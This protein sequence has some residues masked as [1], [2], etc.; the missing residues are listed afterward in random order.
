MTNSFLQRLVHSVHNY[1]TLISQGGIWRC[2]SIRKGWCGCPQ[3]HGRYYRSAT[4]HLPT[5]L[6][7]SPLPL[8]P[9]TI[10][11][12]ISWN[13]HHSVP[14]PPK[15]HCR[16]TPSSPPAKDHQDTLESES[17]LLPAA[18]PESKATESLH[19]PGG[20]CW[21][22]LGVGSGLGNVGR[23]K[24]V[25]ACLDQMLS[26]SRELWFGILYNS[27]RFG[28]IATFS[29]VCDSTEWAQQRWRS[30]SNCYSKFALRFHYTQNSWLKLY[31]SQA[32]CSY[33]AVHVKQKSK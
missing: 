22:K 26:D 21:E 30:C 2:D 11:R 19:I 13:S 12:P 32:P 14:E 6:L 17:C 18:A 5:E 25:G 8:P 7:Q 23:V 4:S 27:G 1:W 24:E 10:P 9:I 28:D 31:W 3:P 16:L 15:C 20:G 33:S 29:I